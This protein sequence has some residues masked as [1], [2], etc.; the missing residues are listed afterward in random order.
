MSDEIFPGQREG[1]LDY[2]RNR[3]RVPT[4]WK[5]VVE[6]PDFNEAA[7][8]AERAVMAQDCDLVLP[9]GYEIVKH[10]HTGDDAW[11]ISLIGDCVGID[12]EAYPVR[13]PRRL[14]VGQD[15]TA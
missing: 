9:Y 10:P 7:M 12:P 3:G 8:L 13:P 6:A 14:I 2:L 4:P 5:V 1:V 11:E 15:G